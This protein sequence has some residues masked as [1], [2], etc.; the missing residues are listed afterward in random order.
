M[1]ARCL[2]RCRRQGPSGPPGLGK[3]PQAATRG[4]THRRVNGRGG[5]SCGKNRVL[6]DSHGATTPGKWLLN[7]SWFPATVTEVV[8]CCRRDSVC[9]PSG[10]ILP[11]LCL[12]YTPHTKDKVTTRASFNPGLCGGRRP[13]NPSY[14]RLWDLTPSAA[15]PPACDR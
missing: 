3:E 4:A 14:V 10:Q 2:G 15:A 9:A 1:T 11:F 6:K 7:G 13:T 8:H 12:V 5:P